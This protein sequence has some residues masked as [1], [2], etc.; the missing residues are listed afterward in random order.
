MNPQGIF[1]VEYA[2]RTA[3]VIPLRDPDEL[4]FDED[5][6]AEI[7]NLFER[8]D[9]G[10]TSHVVVDCE[11]ID[12]CCSSAIGF[13]LKIA[14]RM[15]EQGGN[16]VFCNLSGHLRGVFD[17]LHLEKVFGISDTRDTAMTQVEA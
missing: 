9:A 4:V 11:R 13:F 16:V 12:H 17:M 1:R 10:Q 8:I 14:K 6:E 5:Q 3:I 15:R 2:G 7:A